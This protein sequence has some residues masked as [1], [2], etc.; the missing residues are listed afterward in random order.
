ML[1]NDV[2]ANMGTFSQPNKHDEQSNRIDETY[3]I[4]IVKFNVAV[5]SL[6]ARVGPHLKLISNYP[7]LKLFTKS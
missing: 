4:F 1:M 2:D 3:S 6:L 7:V 5:S